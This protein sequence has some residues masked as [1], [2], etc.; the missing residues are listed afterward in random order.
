M[1]AL[2][3]QLQ[4]LLARSV[5]TRPY[6]VAID[7]GCDL[8]LDRDA[9][10]QPPADIAVGDRA[11]DAPAD[12]QREQDAEPFGVEALKGFLNRLGLGD[13]D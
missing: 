13:G 1:H 2:V 9:R 10:Q 5:G 12:T 4:D 11:D 8:V 7:V 6:E 3:E